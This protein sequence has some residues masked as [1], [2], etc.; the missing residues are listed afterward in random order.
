MEL[1]DGEKPK[2]CGTRT[3]MKAPVI[4]SRVEVMTTLFS[5]LFNDG[6]RS[7]GDSSKICKTHSESENSLINSS[8]FEYTGSVRQKQLYY[9]TYL[10]FVS[11]YRVGRIDTI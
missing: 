1:F 8:L 7:F 2:L 6:S 9:E 3:P 4:L 11:V 5:F 10:A